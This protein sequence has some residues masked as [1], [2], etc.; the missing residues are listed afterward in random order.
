MEPT[1]RG[2]KKKKVS[3]KPTSPKKKKDEPASPGGEEPITEDPEDEQDAAEQAA[4]QALLAEVMR[5]LRLTNPAPEAADYMQANPAPQTARPAPLTAPAALKKV[6]MLSTPGM[7]EPES[8]SYLIANYARF[9]PNA[10]II[11]YVNGYQGLLMGETI[12]IT[13][14]HAKRVAGGN[15]LT[16]VKSSTVQDPLIV[17]D[18][19]SAVNEPSLA[20][21]RGMIQEGDEPMKVAA[22]QIKKDGIQVL[23]SIGGFETTMAAA[24]LATYLAKDGYEL[25]VVALPKTVDNDLYPITQTLG[26]WS[27]TEDG[28]QLFANEAANAPS[29]LPKTLVVHEMAGRDCG[30]LTAS[31]ARRCLDT[32]ALLRSRFASGDP[33]DEL[34]KLSPDRF[35]VHAIYLPEMKI[36]DIDL[37]GEAERLRAVLDKQNVVNVFVAEGLGIAE[38]AADTLPPTAEGEPLP[39]FRDAIGRVD[40][41]VKLGRRSPAER[42]VEALAKAVGAEVTHY[43][44]AADYA[45]AMECNEADR[46]LIAA[47]AT[48]AVQKA[49]LRQPGVVAL[50]EDALE[51]WRLRLVEL[52]RLKQA[53]PF[54]VKLPWFAQML[55]SIGQPVA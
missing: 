7:A 51:I 38:L 21:N 20:V 8:V 52:E 33:P 43:L 27:A 2:P 37:P 48:L 45:R 42:F 32:A 18:L 36:G 3:K 19:K 17:V 41:A 30:W 53:K 4:A 34:A 39:S 25:C 14:E 44:R 13:A 9:H 10:E 22:E 6:A 11:G 55:E 40:P 28:A 26:A 47:S 15:L 46:S 23:H 54:D 16:L 1:P 31:T 29:E 50:D 5:P 12:A 24:E 49:G 35:D